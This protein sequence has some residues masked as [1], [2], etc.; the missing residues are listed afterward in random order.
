MAKSRREV[1][2]ILILLAMAVVSTG[3]AIAGEEWSIGVA[4]VALGLSQF[5]VAAHG[6]IRLFGLTEMVMNR[7][8]ERAWRVV[9]VVMGIL[10]IGLGVMALIDP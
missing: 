5:L 1:A 7:L 4:I 2:Y 6:K 8:P 9:I 10:I 3:A